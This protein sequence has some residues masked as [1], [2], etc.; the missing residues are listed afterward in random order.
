MIPLN[1]A[2]NILNPTHKPMTIL[3][4]IFH[5]IAWVEPQRHSILKTLLLG[6]TDVLRDLELPD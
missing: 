6:T 3:E 1:V 4:V 2:M 5:Y